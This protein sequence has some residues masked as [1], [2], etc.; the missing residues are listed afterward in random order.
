MRGIELLKSGQDKKAAAELRQAV[1][2]LP[3]QAQIRVLYGLALFRSGDPVAGE[4]EART[5]LAKEP[6]NVQALHLLGLCLLRQ[7]KLNEGTEMLESALR[8]QPG[9]I[10]AAATLGTVYAGRGELEKADVLL[11]GP[12]G[13]STRAE[14]FLIRGLVSKGR[15]DWA[16]AARSLET[17]VK[18]SPRLLTAHA[19]LGHT[20]LLMG[21]SSRA[22]QAFLKELGIQ[23]AD[24]HANVYL[25]WHYLKERRYPEALPLLMAASASKPHHPGVNY[26]HG[27]ARH[28]LGEY[29]RAAELLELAVKKQ[30]DL[31]PAHV[32]LAR[33]YAKL[34]RIED[35]RRQQKV[36]ARLRDEEQ[37]RNLG[38]VQ[39]YGSA[40]DVP[41]LEAR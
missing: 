28:A 30:P 39:S 14:S 24:F 38:S 5:V 36:I 7:D 34:G 11:R 8:L 17:A 6:Q 23:P 15:S 37:Q 32:L 1:I 12:L 26:M 22:E 27:Q 33:V 2:L 25:A 31:A 3:E 41:Q 29:S 35:A 19:E 4:Q 9:N 20:Y 18:M 13:T 16:G 40:S 21:E 10:D